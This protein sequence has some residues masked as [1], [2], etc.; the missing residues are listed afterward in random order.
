MKPVIPCILLLSGCL[1][2]TASCSKQSGNDAEKADTAQLYTL[3]N[4]AG[5]EVDVTNFGG[6]ITNILVPDRNGAMQDVVLGFDSIAQY[7]PERNDNNFGATIGRYGNRIA[8]GRMV[9]DSDTIQLPRNN[10][11]HCLHGGPTGWHYQLFKVDAVTDTSIVLSL[12]SPDG[13]NGFPG[14]VHATVSYTLQPDNSLAIAYSAS[15]DKKTVINMTNH[16]YFNLGGDPMKPITDHLL[17]LN[18]D[19]FTPVDSTFMTYGVI[20]PVAGTPMDFTT[21]HA[22]GDSI[23][24]DYEQLHNGNGYDHNYVLNT[25]RDITMPAAMLTSPETGI[26]LTIYTDEPG[27][28]VYSGNFLDGTVTGKKG[29]AYPMRAA[30]CLET[31]HYPNTPNTPEWPSAILEPGKTYNSNTIWKFS[32]AE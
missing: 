2:I 19:N 4:S 12:D 3:K 18:A 6:R 25:N 7:Y 8:Q 29:L 30:I 32:V 15:T 31:Q 9:I 26:T 11:G 22:I 1:F 24:A 14:N 20:S 5:M 16:T 10:F 27:I 17:Y 23:E 21:P 13:D 28:Q